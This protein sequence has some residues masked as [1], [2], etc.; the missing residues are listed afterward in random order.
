VAI[1]ELDPKVTAF[2][3]QD[4]LAVEMDQLFFTHADLLEALG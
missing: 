1:V 2:R 4:D 3:D